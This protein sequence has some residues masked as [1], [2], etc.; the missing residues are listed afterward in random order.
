MISESNVDDPLTLTYFKAYLGGFDSITNQESKIKKPGSFE[1]HDQLITELGLQFLCNAFTNF[2]DENCDTIKVDSTAEA[3]KLILDFLQS[4]GIVFFFDPKNANEAD[5]FDDLLSYC[6]DLCSRTVLSVVSDKME[7]ESDAQGLRAFRI[8][9]MLYFL[10]RKQAIQDSKYAYSL[11]LDLMQELKASERTQRRMDNLVCINVRGKPGEAIHRDKKCEHFVREVKNA[12]KGTH[13]SLKD[14]NVEKTVSSISVVN[15][16]V[17]HD[18]ESMLCNSLSSNTS[19][20]YIGEERRKL[21]NEKVS[22][23]NPFSKSREKVNF[24]DKSKGTPFA[25]MTLEKVQ[26]FLDRNRTNYRRRF[27]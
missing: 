7:E 12:L 22:E 18:L 13:S 21:M 8:S 14:L 5:V 23:V 9:M 10:N 3:E 19:Y 27:T 26:R 2:L 25:G 6:R 17:G 1:V 24:F 4:S 15:R 11:L 16:I 20:D